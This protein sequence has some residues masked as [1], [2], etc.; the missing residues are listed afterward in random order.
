M[1]R[2]IKR[3]RSWIGSAA[4]F[5]VEEFG[6]EDEQWWQSQP[7]FEPTSRQRRSPFD[8]R[9]RQSDFE[10]PRRS[11][12]SPGNSRRLRSHRHHRPMASGGV[13]AAQQPLVSSGVTFKEKN[14]G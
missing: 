13:V 11:L 3:P 6:D 10:A 5:D 14:R 2:S 1:I 12:A 7:T 9:V 8:R 4:F